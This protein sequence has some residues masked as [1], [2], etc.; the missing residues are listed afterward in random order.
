MVL[1]P[2][3]L[4]ESERVCFGICIPAAI[5]YGGISL[6]TTALAAMIQCFPMWTPESISQLN[7]SQQSSSIITG[8]LLISFCGAIG[9]DIS[10]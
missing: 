5:E 3:K 6:V 2:N 1:Y 7:P 9:W 8:P 10:S 4:P